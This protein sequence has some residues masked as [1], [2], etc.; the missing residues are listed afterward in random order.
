M[1]DDELRSEATFNFKVDNF[2]KLNESLFSPP[3]YVRNLP[4]KIMVMPRP[5]INDRSMETKSLGFFLQ[6]NGDSESTTWSC[7]ATAE[8]RLKSFKPGQEDF[9]RKIKHTFFQ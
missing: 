7:S 6:C 8:L 4:W 5:M 3:S 9:V 2:S 1:E